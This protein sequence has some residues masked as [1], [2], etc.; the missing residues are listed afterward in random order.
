MHLVDGA[1]VD[2]APHISPATEAQR[3]LLNDAFKEQ[4]RRKPR[5]D[6][7]FGTGLSGARTFLISFVGYPPQIIKLGVSDMI[8]REANAY[9]LHVQRLAT[10]Y[11]PRLKIYPDLEQP[12]PKQYAGER[13]LIYDEVGDAV[14]PPESI[15]EFFLK[16]YT[17]S[18]GASNGAN[19]AKAFEILVRACEQ[20]WWRNHTFDEEFFYGNEYA[21]LLPADFEAVEVDDARTTD[22][23][24]ATSDDGLTGRVELHDVQIDEVYQNRITL[25]ARLD[26][27][28]QFP[29]RIRLYSDNT[30]R[31]HSQQTIDSLSVM[32]T[33][34]RFEQ[35]NRVAQSAIAD[36]TPD[37]PTFTFENVEFTNPL[38]HLP[39]LLAPT[40]KTIA[41]SIIHG[42]FNLQNILLH[43][44]SHHPW[45]IDFE[46]TCSG[47]T[48]LDFQRLETELISHLLL[49]ELEKNQLPLTTVVT[50]M[51]HLHR[52]SIPALAPMAELQDLYTI[53][54]KVRTMVTDYCVDKLHW[55]EYYHGFAIAL[56][57]TLK[58][59]NLSPE[60]HSVMLITAAT[61]IELMEQPLLPDVAINTRQSAL[62]RL[63]EKRGLKSADA[64]GEIGGQ[65]FWRELYRRI[66]DEK[67]VPIVGDAVRKNRI[68]DI[69]SNNK[70]GV[71]P[72]NVNKTEHRD[73]LDRSASD[74]LSIDAELAEMWAESIGYP[75]SGRR[76]LA[77]V[78]QFN[79]VISV[80]TRQ[81]KSNYLQFLKECL[82]GVAED[83]KFV[84]EK[85]DGLRS[86]IFEKGFSD[87][88]DELEYP[89]FEAE[90]L[91]PLRVLAKLRLPI[92]ITTS[93]FDFLERALQAEGVENVRTRFCLW[94][95]EGESVARE[96]L[97]DPE[98]VPSR[99]EP[100]VYHLHG[101]EMYPRSLVLSED[102]YLDYL[103][104]LS[105]DTNAN[106]P[107]IPLYLRTALEESSLLLLGY[108]LQDWDFRILYR[109]LINT[110]HSRLRMLDR[111]YSIALQ[112]DPQYQ[113]GIKNKEKARQY[114]DDYFKDTNFR[115]EWSSID[116]FTY[117]L[118][119]QWNLLRRSHS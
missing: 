84:A 100:V 114:L 32:F 87:I 85:V 44:Q 22:N 24:M 119:M 104:A 50:L 16:K 4:A 3:Q 92:Y 68:F 2:F 112:L 105:Q 40:R 57:G 98:Y 102:D 59:R 64:D 10:T 49:V 109:G 14:Y 48:L 33:G 1:I 56:I 89:R 55:R 43:P 96:H 60:A 61:V 95:M 67:V 82:L 93:Y 115:V 79:R 45:M 80:D 39:Q 108:R 73:A 116:R 12:S 74:Y 47:P 94:N 113:D 36:F 5:V 6:N 28:A 70:L 103:L 19:I 83:D 8:E 63:K 72:L 77:S 91:D 21:R 99:D 51:K 62:S 26:R 25:I 110:Q 46:K 38:V 27:Q 111:N 11:I 81:A 30:Q 54:A 42:D 101:Y 29:Q 76:R 75:L 13:V 88:V 53:F 106:K 23:Q 71:A 34:N 17:Q 37:D 107:L 117:S 7:E 58:F 86:Q 15:K 9:R 78:A 18:N 118:W 31:F 35:L 97:P 65:D 90:R 52:A 20:R 41:R 69:D 66:L